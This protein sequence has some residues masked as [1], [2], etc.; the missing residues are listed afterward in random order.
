[1]A[2][3]KDQVPTSFNTLEYAK[4][5]RA[6][7]FTQAQAESFYHVVQDQLVSKQDFRRLEKDL[8][9]D[10]KALDRKMQMQLELLRRDLKI[11]FGGMLGA[12]VGVISGITTL[13]SYLLH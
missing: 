11:W 7:G 4:R 6:A 2:T 8:D 10:I 1:M 3:H 9:R 13:T 12:A 5:L